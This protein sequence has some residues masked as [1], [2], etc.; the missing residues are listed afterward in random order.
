MWGMGRTVS[1]GWARVRLF[2]RTTLRRAE[3]M[4]DTEVV[5][6]DECVTETVSSYVSE[7]KEV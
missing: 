3:L 7:E 2:D 5:G 4:M 1:A 6:V